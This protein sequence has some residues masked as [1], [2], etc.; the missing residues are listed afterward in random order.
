M[1]NQTWFAQFINGKDNASSLDKCWKR[2][3]GIIN[4]AGVGG[5]VFL[6]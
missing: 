1:E 4:D 6:S 3:D 2:L 5:L